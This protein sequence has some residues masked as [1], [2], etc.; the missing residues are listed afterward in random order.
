MNWKTKA[1]IQ[2]TLSALPGGMV[3]NDL[4]QRLGSYRNPDAAVDRTVVK[5][6][7]VQAQYFNEMGRS[8]RGLHMVEIGTGWMP[9]FPICYALAGAERCI[10]YD[11]YDHLSEA[12]TL[13]M[14]E[15]LRIH[16]LAIA[17]ASSTSV[18][19]VQA[20]YEQFSKSRTLS[21]LLAATGITYRPNSDASRT[22]L[23]DHS[24]DTVYSNNVLEHVETGALKAIMRE[25]ARIL[26]TGGIAVHD[27]N[28]GDHFAYSDASISQLHY[29][30][31]SSTE[32]ERW[33][34][35]ILYQNRLRPSD[36]IRIAEEAGLEVVLRKSRPHP[37]L[38]KQIPAIAPEFSRYAQEDLSST[39]LALV[40][41][42]A[43]P[44]AG[45]RL[46]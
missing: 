12:R 40:V 38:L 25:S 28:C 31:Y 16:I 17:K 46:R 30:Q 34:N 36:F 39:S 20:R 41:T 35:S 21:D 33:N 19:D 29:L 45:D 14:I 32:W 18:A 4:L 27:V 6:W 1:H 3:V 37:E 10:T 11:L 2:R 7:L 23:P 15:R 13:R 43:C 24:T 5:D 8:I 42:P 22:S 26:K 44:V 9:V